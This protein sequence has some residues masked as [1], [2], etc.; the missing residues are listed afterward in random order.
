M[1][2]HTLPTGAGQGKIGTSDRG[3]GSSEKT[4]AAVRRQGCKTVDS[5]L[6][7]VPESLY[8]GIMDRHKYRKHAPYGGRNGW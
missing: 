2:D 7:L 8:V 1:A 5:R 3:L 4:I 6:V